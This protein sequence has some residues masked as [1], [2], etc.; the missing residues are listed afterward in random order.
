M[1]ENKIV[2]EE[3]DIC[4]A[5]VKAPVL[6]T[7]LRHKILKPQ[8][9]KIRGIYPISQNIERARHCALTVRHLNSE[10]KCTHLHDPWPPELFALLCFGF[11]EAVTFSNHLWQSFSHEY[12]DSKITT[13]VL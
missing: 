3:S 10:C 9:K 2:N 1:F 7:H 11:L 6:E 12:S 13:L 5:A 4:K 8:T